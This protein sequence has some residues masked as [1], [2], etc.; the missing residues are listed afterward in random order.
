MQVLKKTTIKGKTYKL[1][2]HKGE[3]GGC[4]VT[5]NGRTGR[6]VWRFQRPKDQHDIEDFEIPPWHPVIAALLGQ[7]IKVFTTEQVIHIN[8]RSGLVTDIR[9]KA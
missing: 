1:C 2:S 8:P 3:A 5:C 7:R 6:C 4:E 9:P